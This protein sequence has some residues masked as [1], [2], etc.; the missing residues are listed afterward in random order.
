MAHT[1]GL[2][3]YLQC[4]RFLWYNFLT[5]CNILEEEFAASVCVPGSKNF[6]E[7]RSCFYCGNAV[8]KITKGMGFAE[9]GSLLK[10]F[11][12]GAFCG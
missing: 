9:N 7:S 11:S 6:G 3:I 12:L 8:Q 1:V 10:R 5:L 4:E 2:I